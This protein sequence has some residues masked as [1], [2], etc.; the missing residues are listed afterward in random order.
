[1]YDRIEDASM[2]NMPTIP[3]ADVQRSEL[4]KQKRFQTNWKIPSGDV[5]G[6]LSP[7]NDFRHGKHDKDTLRDGGGCT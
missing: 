5:L 6:T 4:R 1:M 7:W 2:A 3:W